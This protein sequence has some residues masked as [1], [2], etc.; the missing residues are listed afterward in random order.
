MV[1]VSIIYMINYS[2]IESVKKI[3]INDNGSMFKWLPS[4]LY[5]RDLNLCK[6]S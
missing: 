5:V 4:F 1:H 6:R 2:S 3:V